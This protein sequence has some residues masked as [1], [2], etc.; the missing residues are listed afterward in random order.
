MARARALG[1][2]LSRI[3]DE[4]KVTGIMSRS[5]NGLTESGKLGQIIGRKLNIQRTKVILQVCLPLH[6][7]NRQDVL[8]LGQQPGKC[9]LGCGAVFPQR[10]DFQDL[11]QGEVFCQI[12]LGKTGHLPAIVTFGKLRTGLHLPSEQTSAKRGECHQHRAEF[13]A[14]W[15]Y[16]TF[17]GSAKKAVF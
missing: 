15:K 17:R 12:F 5:L 4:S 13:A 11:Y 3:F 10:Q 8:P 6:A 7:G 14:E 16:C 9:D 1:P 2:S